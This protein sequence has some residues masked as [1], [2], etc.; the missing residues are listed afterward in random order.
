MTEFSAYVES[1][2]QS[3]VKDGVQCLQMNLGYAC[4][5]TCSHCHLDAG[6]K[7]TETMSKEVID[8]CLRFAQDSAVEVIDITGGAP[9]LNRHLRHLVEGARRLN[10][11]RSIK[12]RSNLTLLGQPGYADLPGF[13]ADN[14]VEIV[15]SLPCYLEENVAAQRGAGVYPRSIEALKDL[16]RIGYGRAEGPRLHLV[17]NPAGGFL[18]A[19]QPGLEKAYRKHLSERFGIS[20][21]TLFTIANMPLG[22]FRQELERRG[23][24][25]SYLSLLSD[26]FNSDNLGKVMCRNQISVDWQ[27]QVYDCDFNQ[28]LKLPVPLADS[29]IGNISMDQL[30]GAPVRLGQHCFAC[31][32][33]CGSSCHG[34]LSH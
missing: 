34:S 10:S 27:G 33:G 5:L 14:E 9:E 16:N 22:R 18:P 17:F 7:R 26:N 11:V 20:F 32:A 25:Q 3:V 28:A 31:T 2:G 1:S 29:Y 23:A 19:P 15:A 24:L 4:N 13:L 6:P 30:E 8:D 12:L 21:S